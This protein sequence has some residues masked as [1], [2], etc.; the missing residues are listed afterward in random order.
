LAV[1]REPQPLV[2]LESRQDLVDDVDE[3]DSK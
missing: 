3:R 2:R 1:E